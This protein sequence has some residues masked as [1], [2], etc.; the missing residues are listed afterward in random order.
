MPAPDENLEVGSGSHA[1]QT[2]EEM[3]RFEPVALE[4]KPDIVL[5]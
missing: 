5:V 3:K 1:M 2:A 4:R